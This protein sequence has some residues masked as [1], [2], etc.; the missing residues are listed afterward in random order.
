MI[1]RCIGLSILNKNN[2]LI[3]IFY[4]L[5]GLFNKVMFDCFVCACQFLFCSAYFSIIHVN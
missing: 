5:I 4:I 1:D 3:Y 2:L